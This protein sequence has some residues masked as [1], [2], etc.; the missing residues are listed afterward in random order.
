MTGVQPVAVPSMMFRNPDFNSSTPVEG[1]SVGAYVSAGVV[2]G[3][4]VVV[5][6]AAVVG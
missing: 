1:A 4:T 6:I 2:V 5:G 3:Y